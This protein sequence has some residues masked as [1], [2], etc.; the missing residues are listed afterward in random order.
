MRPEF[1]AEYL[2]CPVCRS[3]RSLRLEA[4][5]AD[6][7]EVREGRLRCAS[8]ETPICLRCQV[9][10]EVGLK[11]PSCAQPAATT[12]SS[13]PSPSAWPDL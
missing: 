9:R 13:R 2:R 8:C 4:D 1:A 10:T 6:E 3:E 7:R 5:R 11:C 12:R